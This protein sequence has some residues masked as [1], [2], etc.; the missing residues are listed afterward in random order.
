MAGSEVD[1]DL[2]VGLEIEDDNHR[3]L[4]GEHITFVNQNSQIGDAESAQDELRL[5]TEPQEKLIK[6]PL[7]R[8][9]GIMKTDPDVKIASQDAVIILAKAAVSF[10]TFG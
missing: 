1:Q 8:I 2:E 5:E 3:E 4:E 6:L 10:V 9:R 7:S